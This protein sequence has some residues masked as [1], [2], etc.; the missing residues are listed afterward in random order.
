MSI[1]KP[2]SG[3][4][5]D[6]DGIVLDTGTEIW[7]AITTHLDLPWSI[8]RFTSYHI[9]GVVER[10]L[11]ELRPIY[12][13]VLARTDLPLIQG[14][15]DALTDFY[16]L[17]KEPLL[18]I[19]ARRPRFVES[20]RA[21]M[22]RELNFPFEI[23]CT[24]QDHDPAHCQAGHDKRAFLKDHNIKV[25]IDDHAPLWEYYL[26]AGF[27]IGSLDW[28]WTRGKAMNFTDESK[29]IGKFLFFQNWNSINL[30]ISWYYM[31]NLGGGNEEYLQTGL[32]G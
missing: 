16:E 32:Y 22:E 10:P 11:E 23:I 14:A 17:V 7:G 8:E 12:E 25:F 27:I 9:E 26:D 20:A 28:P 19:T 3:V 6:I 24:S 30:F 13:P 1:Y 18:F 21:S 15:A 2:K 5:F 4:A 31:V 29:Y